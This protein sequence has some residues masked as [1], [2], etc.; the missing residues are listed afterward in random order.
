MSLAVSLRPL[1]RIVRGYRR[2]LLGAV[3]SGVVDQALAVASAAVGAW[4]VGAAITGT[5]VSELR[6]GLIALAM[7]VLPRAAM[8]WLESY[9]A[10]DM[11]FRVL[12]DIREELYLGFER[13]APSAQRG[14]RS[15]DLVSTAMDD[16]ERLEVFFAHTLSPLVVAVVVPTGSLAAL[17]FIHPG[18]ALALLPI[19]VLVASVPAWLR[20]RAERQ[21]RALRTTLGVVNA[22]AVDGV[23]GLREIVAFNAQQDF[24]DQL[25]ERTRDLHKAQLAHGSRTGAERAAADGLI[26]LGV[27][28]T[29]GTAAALVTAG[30]MAAALYPTAVVLAGAALA[31]VGKLGDAGRELGIV[32]AASAR[33][34]S[35]IDAPATV[36]DEGTREL[37]A[38]ALD[39]TATGLAFRQVS[40]RYA[41][42]LPLA[43]NDVTFDVAPG[44]TVA[45]VGHSGAGKSTLA[46]L[47]VRFWDVTNGS[48][49]IA[50]ID[51]RELPQHTLRRLVSFVPQDVHLLTCSVADN[52]ALA[53]PGASRAEI[54]NAARAAHAHE[55][56]VDELP[57]GYDTM[58]GEWGGRLSGG[59]RQRIAIARALLRDAPILV[60][61][62]PVSN[63]DGESERALRLAMSRVRAGRT[64]VLVAHRMSTIRSADR[65]VVL[66][67]GRVAE[68]G[69]H[70]QLLAAGG[71]YS[72]LVAHQAGAHTRVSHVPDQ[73]KEVMSHDS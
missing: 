71:A 27:I 18:L 32:T 7:L 19:A 11:A 15:G 40:F 20:R 67:R 26:A 39:G 41:P 70:T 31:P 25:D 52:I 9:L 4:L 65:L 22:E 53:R 44:E 28:I 3:G 55:F 68:S 60:M 54:E 33:V 43:V 61:D 16:V 38:P 2:H 29:L 56:I 45:L 42:D 46:H 5:P 62:E 64:T 66:E 58:V 69:T 21:G 59:Q 63:L 6:P 36:P 35:V 50:G 51:V 48:V 13:Q 73:D 24:L 34:F 47:L 49:C 10:H 1:F 12:V 30:S 8:G 23:Q 37:P 57:E 72:R 14:Q 17:W